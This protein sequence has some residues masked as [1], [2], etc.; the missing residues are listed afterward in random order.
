MVQ[1]EALPAKQWGLGSTGG[2]VSGHF[3]IF[4]EVQEE[5]ITLWEKNDERIFGKDIVCRPGE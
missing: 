4:L 3:I 1:L 2:K 5:G